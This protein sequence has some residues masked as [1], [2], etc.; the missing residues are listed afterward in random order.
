MTGTI[1]S[2]WWALSA[3]AAVSASVTISQDTMH[4]IGR[5]NLQITCAATTPRISWGTVHWYYSAARDAGRLVEFAG[6]AYGAGD[7]D[8]GSVTLTG[9]EVALAGAKVFPRMEFATCEDLAVSGAI[10]TKTNI[11]GPDILFDPTISWTGDIVANAD[12]INETWSKDHIPV[13]KNVTACFVLGIHPSGS[14]EFTL[15]F[16]EVGAGV[17]TSVLQSFLEAD[18]FNGAAPC[19]DFSIRKAGPVEFFVGGTYGAGPPIFGHAEL[20]PEANGDP[21]TPRTG[22]S[23]AG[24]ELVMALLLLGVRRRRSREPSA[25]ISSTGAPRL[26]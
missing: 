12:N 15:D 21:E 10:D 7:R 24:G 16:V 5:T 9:D 19:I 13:G 8:Q 6:G 20:V 23:S 1:V 22:C 4:A 11:D 14:E 25:L 17:T 26:R 18:S 3:G 2:V